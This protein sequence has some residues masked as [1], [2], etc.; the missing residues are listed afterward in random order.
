MK[1]RVRKDPETRRGELIDAA[2]KVFADKGFE[3]TAVSDIVKQAGVA[4]GTFY[5][6]F[7]T[8][9]DV[10]NALVDRMIEQVVAGLDRTVMQPD[11]GAVQRFR[12]LFDSFLTL[13]SEPVAYELTA[14]YHSE[15]NRAVHEEMERRMMPRLAEIV[16]SIVRAGNSEGV[17]NAKDPHLAASFVLGGISSIEA[18]FVD[19]SLLPNYLESAVEFALNALG[20]SGRAASDA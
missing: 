5:L 19:R 1:K 2:Q 9:H 10:V 14:V 7:K 6:Y 3:R 4:Q 15:E 16:E 18:A 13:A 12:S 17:F 11:M 20:Y 8:K